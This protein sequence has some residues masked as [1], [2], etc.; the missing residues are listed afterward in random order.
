M[1]L[2]SSYL[3]YI[4]IIATMSNKSNKRKRPLPYSGNKIEQNPEL[5]QKVILGE[6]IGHGAYGNV[7]AVMHVP[8]LAVKIE[9]LRGPDGEVDDDIVQMAVAQMDSVWMRWFMKT[10]PADYLAKVT[11]PV[12]ALNGT[13]DLQVPV[14]QNLPVIERVVRESGGDITTHRLEGLNHLFQ[15]AT[16]GTVDEYPRIE[17]TFDPAAMELISNWIRSRMEV[18]Q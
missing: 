5:I 12:L 10:D 7:H 3:I 11:C 17:T 18:A 1:P 4:Y 9:N 8:S 16:K 13:L 15:P 2:S 14:D 6:K